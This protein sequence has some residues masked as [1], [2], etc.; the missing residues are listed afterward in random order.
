MNNMKK[1]KTM[2]LALCLLVLTGML[3]GCGRHVKTATTYYSMV[4]AYPNYNF[5]RLEK[6]GD[7]YNNRG[8]KGTY[9]IKNKTVTFKDEAGGISE[10]YLDGDYL[11][12]FAYDKGKE[13]IPDGNLFNAKVNDTHSNISFKDDGSFSVLVKE[14]DP[15]E[16]NAWKGSY[17]R[18]GNIITCTVKMR[19]GGDFTQVYG[20]RDGLLYNAYCSDDSLFDSD[21][22]ATIEE[23]EKKARDQESG[24][25]G[26]VLIVSIMLAV[27]ALIVFI[28]IYSQ[29][30]KQKENEDRVKNK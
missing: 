2:I 17:V 12:Y 28:I 26:V 30:K 21:V 8:M 22:I 9:E 10:G 7:F 25:L 3:A 11:F 15:T 19:N 27:L 13:K 16:A 5:Y 14:A 29:K 18:E 24:M 6:D 20:V 4:T 1:K 23:A